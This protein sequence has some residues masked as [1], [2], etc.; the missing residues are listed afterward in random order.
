MSE[1]IRVAGVSTL[2]HGE[3]RSF[4]FRRDGDDGAGFVLRVGE[5]LVAF[6]NRCPHWMVDLDMG[7]GRFFSRRAQRIVCQNH[8]AL[9]DPQTGVCEVGPC[10]GQALERFALEVDGDV[11]W[12]EVPGAKARMT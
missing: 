9:F 7:E 10:V 12:V 4:F 6:E 1:R 3:A 5:A 11:A 8:G 2:G